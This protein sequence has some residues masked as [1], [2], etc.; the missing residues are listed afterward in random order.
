[1][2]TSAKTKLDAPKT[3]FKKVVH[4]TVE[5]TGEFLGNKIADKILC[6]RPLADDNSGNAK[7][8][9]IPPEKRQETLNVL[10]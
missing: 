4:K 5:A 2:D 6:L 7:E 9:F 3:A 8:I 10:K 1:M